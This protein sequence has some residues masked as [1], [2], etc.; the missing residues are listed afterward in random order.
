MCSRLTSIAL[1]TKY[2]TGL[3]GLIFAAEAPTP[4]MHDYVVLDAHASMAR[5]TTP[6]HLSVRPRGM[7]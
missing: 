7:T 2:S 6:I 5:V 4:E 1:I 3:N